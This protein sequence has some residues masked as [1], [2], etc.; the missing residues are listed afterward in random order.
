MES[1]DTCLRVILQHAH[2][3]AGPYMKRISESS[4]YVPNQSNPTVKY[5]ISQGMGKIH[6]EKVSVFQIMRKENQ[7]KFILLQTQAGA[8]GTALI[9]NCALMTALQGESEQLF[10]RF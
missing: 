9:A 6:R 2:D 8:E 5:Q 7:Q 10:L 4:A 3:H 1:A